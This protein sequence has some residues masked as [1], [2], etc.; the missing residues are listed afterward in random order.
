MNSTFGQDIR[1]PRE[2]MGYAIRVAVVQHNSNYG[3]FEQDDNNNSRVI[4]GREKSVMYECVSEWMRDLFSGFNFLNKTS[5]SYS[6]LVV[7]K[8]GECLNKAHIM[9]KDNVALRMV[10]EV[11]KLRMEHKFRSFPDIYFSN[12]IVAVTEGVISCIQE[13]LLQQFCRLS[14]EAWLNKLKF[15]NK[16]FNFS[17]SAINDRLLPL[18]ECGLNYKPREEDRGYD[19]LSIDVLNEYRAKI[20]RKRMLKVETIQQFKEKNGKERMGPIHKE[21]FKNFYKGV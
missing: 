10:V 20:M 12:L 15:K 14:E 9:T 21:Y 2:S 1:V 8:L 6:E 13:H 18:I 17:K 5:F 19:Q 4:I 16:I 11:N 7:D 3:I